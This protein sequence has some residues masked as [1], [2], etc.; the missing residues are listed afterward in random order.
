MAANKELDIIEVIIKTLLIIK[1]YYLIIIGF[2][3]IGVSV[4]IIDFYVNKNYYKTSLVTKSPIINK[5][6]VFE[7]IKPIEHYI[8]KEMYDS[9]SKEI[10]IPINICKEIKGIDLDTN[11]TNAVK[12]NFEIYN[13]ES[14][15]EIK[16]GIISYLNN[17][18]YVVSTI[19][20]RKMEL[21]EYIKNI[22]KDIEELNN[23][24]DAVIT[25]LQENKT[26]ELVSYGGIFSD[27][28]ELN[29]KKIELLEEYNSLEYFQFINNSL[30]VETQKSLKKN[31]LITS[32]IGLV[33]SFIIS[34][35]FELLIVIKD[36]NND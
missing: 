2:T 17:I 13:M 34:L 8:D 18:P 20:T 25:K 35:F 23:L 31:I 14:F 5:Q 26:T 28:I 3:V 1:K 32:L 21:E 15:N 19:D 30:V 4:G 9:L 6:I 24:Q 29:D 22:D 7:L 12:I 27:I 33:I 10:N 16:Q 11:I 36:R